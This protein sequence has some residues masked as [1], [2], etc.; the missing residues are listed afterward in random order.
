MAY[1]EALAA[2]VRAHLDDHPGFTFKKM[3]G[4]IGFM[5]GG[6]LAAGV[7]N[8]GRLMV[9]CSKE[10]FDAFRA[11]PHGGCMERGGKPMPGWLLIDPPGFAD[12]AG[13]AKWVLRG[14][15]YAAG[16]PPKKK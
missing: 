10:D 9:R 6:H 1:D 2:R 13:L 12:D 16:L 15:D 11:E 3:F 14:R 5:I 7:H 4:G 8:D